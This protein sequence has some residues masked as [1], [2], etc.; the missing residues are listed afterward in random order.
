MELFDG[1]LPFDTP[2]PIELIINAMKLA[3]PSKSD[4]IILDF[5]SGSSASAHAVMKLNA[6]DGGN[7]K[8]ILAQLPE[9]CEEGSEAAKA[10]YKN[11]C[12][13][14]EERIRRAGKKLAAEIEEENKK[15]KPGEQPKHVPDIGFRV[16]KIDSS[17]FENVKAEPNSYQ[18][19]AL[20]GLVDNLKDGRTEED[21]LF[22]VLPQF[23]IPLSVSIEVLD[24]DG[25][26]VFSVDEGRLLACFDKRVSTTCI[27]EMAKMNPDYAV[28]RDASFTSDDAVSNFD[29]LFKI[30]SPATI[31][32]VI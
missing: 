25:S 20:L 29:E 28:M 19:Q 3:L 27:T 4:D 15:L 21:I 32:R 16:F 1:M 24:I 30:Y 18:Q 23:Q 14:G 11:I 22:Q 13:I 8:F 26:K 2:K 6:E 17:N 12:E 7:R 9:V 31:T 5:F 10:G